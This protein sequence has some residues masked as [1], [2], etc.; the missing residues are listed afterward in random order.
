MTP[1]E[2]VCSICQST[3]V[4][5]EGGWPNRHITFIVAKKAYFTVY[6]ALFMVYVGGGVG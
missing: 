1:K 4:W 6:F 3:V 2:R 5:G